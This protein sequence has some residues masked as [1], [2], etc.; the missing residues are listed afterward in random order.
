[1]KKIIALLLLV[2]LFSACRF[3]G[4]RRVRG[5]GNVI[6]QNR[7]IG[8]FSG[9]RVLGGMDAVL[10]SG[11]AYAVNV[12]TDANLQKYILTNREGDVLV[13]RT[14]NG[15]NLH[16]DNNIKIYVTAP[17]LEE[18]TI[19]GSGSVTSAEKLAGSRKLQ[20]HVNGSGDV[21]LDVDAPEVEAETNGSGTI[22]L[23]GTTKQFS[24]EINGSGDFKCFNLLSE[25]TGVEISGSGDAQVFASKQ[26]DIDIR[27][28]GDVAY[29]GTPAIRQRNA[30]S[31]SVR[32]VQ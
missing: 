8:S 12:E 11:T 29:K 31:G 18:I 23:A 32:N 5:N 19:G 9:V 3:T 24:A 7:N 10:R 14:R 13:I 22:I 30:G 2:V 15:Y 28:S 20:I 27:G 21:K 6:M 17:A 4:G 16:S 25:T 26:L 1:M